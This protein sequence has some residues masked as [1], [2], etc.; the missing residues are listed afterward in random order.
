MPYTPA[1]LGTVRAKAP[2]TRRRSRRRSRPLTL[3]MAGR[4]K[5]KEATLNKEA[6]LCD[7]AKYGDCGKICK[8]L[9]GGEAAVDE[10]TKVAHPDTGEELKVTALVQAVLNQQHEAVKLLLE[11]G[12]KPN[13][14]DSFG[15]TPLFEA[16]LCGHRR[17]LQ[18]LLECDAVQLII[19]IAHPSSGCTPFHAACL[20]GHTDCAVLLSCAGCDMT[21]RNKDGETGKEVAQRRQHTAVLAGLQ[22]LVLNQLQTGQ[23]DAPNLHAP[24]PSSTAY[25]ETGCDVGTLLQDEQLTPTSLPA[26]AEPAAAA[27]TDAAD[28]TSSLEVAVASLRK[29][30]PELGIKKI[31]LRVR[32][33]FPKLEVSSKRVKAALAANALRAEQAEQAPA[34]NGDGPGDTDPSGYSPASS[35]GLEPAYPELRTG[36]ILEAIMVV[37]NDENVVQDDDVAAAVV[38]RYPHASWVSDVSG[39]LCRALTNDMHEKC[40]GADSYKVAA[41]PGS[42]KA[43]LKAVQNSPPLKTNSV[44][45]AIGAIEKQ[46]PGKSADQIA[47]HIKRTFP[48]ASWYNDINP[49]L[50]TRI[51][52]EQA[53]EMRLMQEKAM[54]LKETRPGDGN[55]YI[56]TSGPYGPNSHKEIRNK[57]PGVPEEMHG[58]IPEL[59]HEYEKNVPLR[60]VKISDVQ[61]SMLE[62][63]VTRGNAYAVVR[64]LADGADANHSIRT[65]DPIDKIEGSVSMLTSAASHGSADVMQILLNSGASIDHVCEEK[66]LT[67]LHWACALGQVDCVEV[68]VRA[69]CDT[70]IENT[71]NGD[72]ARQ[73]AR[74]VKAPNVCEMID[75]LQREIKI[76][77]VAMA[78]QSDTDE[79]WICLGST[80]EGGNT[81]LI[82]GCACRG[83]AGLAHL[84]CLIDLSKSKLEKLTQPTTDNLKGE[85]QPTPVQK[86]EVCMSPWEHCDTCKQPYVGV[87]RLGLARA[88]WELTS[89]SFDDPVSMHDSVPI[90]TT[91]PTCV[92]V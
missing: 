92:S 66:G 43:L 11:R 27:V 21:L 68:L 58:S 20:Q 79:C 87:V 18:M 14:P 48:H 53:H 69:G 65:Y 1:L 15:V 16:A 50:V 52:R 63:A 24:D 2:H 9:D 85:F 81:E 42:H 74:R 31:V 89:T 61:K 70:E 90:G 40:H 71:V 59:I 4:K 19:N 73:A 80:T 25:V 62:D 8:L 23:M 86:E 54:M 17:I 12:A 56:I 33:R 3:T 88:R 29:E 77:E 49:E 51:Q 60:E 22:T 55:N 38:K 57:Y 28:A 10:M 83:S 45:E 41:R 82:R 36:S 26:D 34:A 35:G 37:F 7:A 30:H 64:A 6:A 32:E 76:A 5:N 47:G 39:K 84:A 46:M 44:M 75:R 91:F 78:K 72:T 67:A 13:L